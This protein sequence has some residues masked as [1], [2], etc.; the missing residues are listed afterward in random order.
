[1]TLFFMLSGFILSYRY[2]TFSCPEDVLLY[3]AARI[4]RL[5]P[6]YLFMGVTTLWRLSEGLKQYWLVENFGLY[7]AIPFAIVAVFLF[8]FALQAW[9]PGLF[10]IWNFGGSW[11][12]SVETFFYALFPKLRMSIG[13]L[14]DRALRIVTFGIPVLI[15]L[16]SL[17]MLV[18]Y[19][20][21]NNTSMVFYVL[22]IFRLPEFVFGVCGYILFVERGIDRNRLAFISSLFF[23][24]LV[25]AIYSYDFPGL[26]EWGSL[27]SFAF[28]GA[29]VFCLKLDASPVVKRVVNYLGRISYCVYLAQFTSIPVIKRFRGYFSVEEEWILAIASTLVVAVITYHFVEVLAYAQTRRI[30]SAVSRSAWRFLANRRMPT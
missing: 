14:G 9:F 17:G 7:G 20:E 4:A 29:F 23:I 2:S 12:L 10:G 28:M 25:I 30:A 27:A 16:I 26:I 21:A 6:V 18:S 24:F 5:Y 19:S 13:R 11:S 22:P 1:M 3:A 15:A 8:T